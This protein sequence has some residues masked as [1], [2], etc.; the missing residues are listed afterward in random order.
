MPNLPER[1]CALAPRWRALWWLAGTLILLLGWFLL[2]YHPARQQLAGLKAQ[3]AQASAVNAALWA[4]ARN[5]YPSSAEVAPQPVVPFTPLAFNHKA[6]RL[7]SW[8][9]VSG[10]GE[11]ILEAEWERIPAL[12]TTLARH[13]VAVRQFSVEP[14]QNGL[15]VVVQLERRDGG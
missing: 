8:R 5:A 11:L 9:P 12:F 3:R 2:L 6:M 15:Q 14:Q 10:G 4:A 7:A 13:D 1:W